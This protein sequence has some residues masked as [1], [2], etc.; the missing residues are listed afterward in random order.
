MNLKVGRRLTLHLA[1]MLLL[2]GAYSLWAATLTPAEHWSSGTVPIELQRRIDLD[3]VE[4]EEFDATAVDDSWAALSAAIA[5]ARYVGDTEA[6]LA[7]AEQ[8]ATLRPDLRG[9]VDLW[10][11]DSLHLAGEPL[12]AQAWYQSVLNAHALEAVDGALLGALAQ[13]SIVATQFELADYAAAARSARTLLERFGA[14]TDREAALAAAL[15]LEA[16]ETGSLGP[17]DAREI[18]HGEPALWSTGLTIEGGS[19]TQAPR[20][21]SVPLRGAQ[22]VQFVLTPADLALLDAPERLAPVSEAVSACTPASASDGFRD[23]ITYDSGNFGYLFLEADGNAGY[24]PGVDLNA[25]N[26]CTLDFRSVARGCVRDTMSGPTDR[27]TIL[28][29]H[30]YVPENFVSNYMHGDRVYYS[31]GMAVSK[32]ALLGNVDGVPSFSCHLHFEIREADHPY[33]LDSTKYLNT[34]KS[35]VADDY[36]EPLSFISAHR[37]Y[38]S[39]RWVDEGAFTRYGTWSVVS[40]TGHSDDSMW[41]GA[42]PSNYA[43]YT[44]TPSTS[45]TYSVK[46]FI[47]YRF[48]TTTSATYRLKTSSGSTLWS[49]TIDQS[50]RHDEWVDLRTAS[51]TSGNSYRLEVYGSG[52]GT[53][54]VVVDDFLILRTP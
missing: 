22:G 51:L 31:V 26:D 14:W 23:P 18:L 54:T 49:K 35:V 53:K 27:G 39:A 11:G 38:A 32:G 1:L 48:G 20:G 21:R 17:L 5:D 37:S 13:R 30:Y 4:A 7:L 28:V 33:R 43:R 2:S 40:G 44:F 6:A 10:N 42:D 41:A 36:D 19:L 8:A 52:G 29:E 50:S 16:V 9:L 45:G 25:P 24:H 12:L 34:S 15:V 47:P 3:V 46:A